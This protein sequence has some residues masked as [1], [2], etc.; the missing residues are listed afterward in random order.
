M[1]KLDPELVFIPPIFLLTAV[2]LF[3]GVRA[4]VTEEAEYEKRAKFLEGEDKI[5]YNTCI[6]GSKSSCTVCI[7]KLD[8]G[9]K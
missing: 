2:L 4:C 8:R 6:L 1:K 3:F 9:L 7:H 5:D